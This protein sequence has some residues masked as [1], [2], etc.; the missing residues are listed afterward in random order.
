MIRGA[1]FVTGNVLNKIKKA[2]LLHPTESASN[3]TSSQ[4]TLN[5]RDTLD[6]PHS[7]THS[8][9]ELQEAYISKL[10]QASPSN[11]PHNLTSWNSQAS[12]LISLDSLLTGDGDSC[13][14]LY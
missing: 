9:L 5:S 2:N 4:L 11:G 1:G 3:S 13:S 7:T 12:S 14:F 8:S 6:A 10:A